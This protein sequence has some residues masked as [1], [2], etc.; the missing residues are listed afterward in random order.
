MTALQI[1]TVP[2]DQLADMIQVAVEKALAASRRAS[3]GDLE[4][5]SA[6]QA[7]KLVHRRPA[8]VI[9]ACASGALPATRTGKAWAIAHRDLDAWA[10]A[11]CPP[12]S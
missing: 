10:A 7:A 8:L 3:A 11:G 4:R 5:L 1:V 2:A 9:A 6:T 12:A